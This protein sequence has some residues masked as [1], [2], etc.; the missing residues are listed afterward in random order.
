MMWTGFICIRKGPVVG[1]CEHCTELSYF[2]EGE[3]LEW[4]LAFQEEFCSVELITAFKFC[5]FSCSL[6][7]LTQNFHN[8]LCIQYAYIHH[9][10]L[11]P[12]SKKSRG[13]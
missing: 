8:K 5:F 10:T 6:F 3:S 4:L 13:T 11:D 1:C 2:T 12:V 9:E 7:L